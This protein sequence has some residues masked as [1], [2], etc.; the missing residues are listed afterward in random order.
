MEEMAGDKPFHTFIKRKAHF[1]PNFT[2]NINTE[3]IVHA[4][5]GEK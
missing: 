1:D 2:E 4:R 5:G 3:T